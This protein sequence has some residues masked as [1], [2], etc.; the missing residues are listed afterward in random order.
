MWMN[1]KAGEAVKRKQ[2]LS[3]KTVTDGKTRGC[4][5]LHPLRTGIP[6]H[7]AGASGLPPSWPFC[8][9]PL[10]F[11]FCH[12]AT[13]EAWPFRRKGKDGNRNICEKA[14]NGRQGEHNGRQG[15]P[16]RQAERTTTAG[17]ENNNGRL[18]EQQ[19][20]VGRTTTAGWENNKNVLPERQDCTD[21]QRTSS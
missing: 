20:Q 16:Q 3:R 19:R 10:P 12:W 5:L 8:W 17:R 7:G 9:W 2:I 15:E 6:L 1:T 18:G 21:K 14:R 11:S 13:S 4:G